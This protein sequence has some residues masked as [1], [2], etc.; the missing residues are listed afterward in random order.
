MEPGSPPELTP[1]IASSTTS[2]QEQQQSS[3]AVIPTNVM[4]PVSMPVVMVPCV[5]VQGPN[6]VPMPIPIAQMSM[7]Q[8]QGQQN[9]QQLS[10]IQPPMP[11]QPMMFPFGGMGIQNTACASQGN[12]TSTFQNHGF[13]TRVTFNNGTDAKDERPF[14]S[15]CYDS[16]ANHHQGAH[17]PYRNRLRPNRSRFADSRDHVLHRRQDRRWRGLI[18]RLIEDTLNF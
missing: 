4:I 10:F 18:V 3:A 13:G 7:S 9:P 14:A 1:T 16:A 15:S 12:S 17:T 6:G 5:M 8:Q 11:Q 2:I